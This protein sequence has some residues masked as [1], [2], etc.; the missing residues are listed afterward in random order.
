MADVNRI[1]YIGADAHPANQGIVFA[2]EETISSWHGPNNPLEFYRAGTRS[3]R[4]AAFQL[5]PDRHGDNCPDIPLKVHAVITVDQP[6]HHRM[7]AEGRGL[8]LYSSEFWLESGSQTVEIGPFCASLLVEC[9]FRVAINRWTVVNSSNGRMTFV[10]DVELDMYFFLGSTTLPLTEFP[11]Q[12]VHVHEL[13]KRTIPFYEEVK[14]RDFAHVESKVVARVVYSLWKLGEADF[15]YD[16]RAGDTSFFIGGHFQLGRML[17]KQA[18]TVNCFDMAALVYAGLKS[19]GKR[20]LTSV[21]G[22]ET[23][24]STRFCNKDRQSSLTD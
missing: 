22:Q 19:F 10:D 3:N 2:D 5:M 23:D 21:G 9:P 13:V 4:C 7:E 11:K 1:T 15:R 16:S 8:T 12:Q 17:K 14:R 6:G 24:V 20:P 18:R